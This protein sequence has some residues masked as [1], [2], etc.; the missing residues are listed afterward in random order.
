MSVAKSVAQSVARAVAAS[1]GVSV[2]VS[3]GGSPLLL[4]S[5]STLAA[6]SLRKLRTGYGG[7]AVRVRRSSDS[8][9]QDI[10]FVGSQF[11][12]ASLLSFCGGG[13]GFVT[14][15]YD[16]SGNSRNLQQATTTKQPRIVN[17]GV[18]DAN[19]ITFDG[20]DD[21]LAVASWGSVA[22]PFCRN[23]VVAISSGSHLLNNA[24]GTPN[25]ADYIAGAGQLGMF[26]GS[27]VSASTF[28]ANQ[29]TVFTSKFNGAASFQSKNGVDSSSLNPGTTGLAGTTV[30][31]SSGSADYS[32]ASW[33]ELIVANFSDS[34][35]EAIEDNQIA[36]Y[37]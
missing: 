33:L 9:E 34:D 23:F 13:S 25:T 8:T 20:T 31:S 3:G 26:A 2:G 18:Q 21:A 6:Y 15:W 11:D 19:G 24:S 36:R 37:V 22:Q 28:T 7:S 12:S 30:G 27:V 4:D 16:Q 5:I 35:R 1:V 32:A 17:A 29:K 10:G 14:T